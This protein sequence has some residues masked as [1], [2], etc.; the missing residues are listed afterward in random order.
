MG[1]LSKRKFEERESYLTTWLL[2]LIPALTL[3]G[4]LGRSMDWRLDWLGEFKMQAAALSFALFLW[5]LF[6]REWIKTSVFLTLVL[7]NLALIA[8]HS[9]LF[10][11][12][13]EL[14]EDSHVFT[15]TYQNLQGAEHKADKLREVLENSNADIVL[16]VNVP[17]QIYRNLDS[18]LGDYQLQ[19]QTF[20]TTGKMKLILSRT[21]GVDRGETA[22]ENGLWVSR[23]VG[24][25]KLTIVLTDI[26]DPWHSDAY[27]RAKQK[28]ADLSEFALSRDEPVVLAGNFGASGWS[29]LL[30]DLETR[31]GL[32]PRGKLSESGT[33]LPLLIRRP[34]DHIY[35]HPGI[36]V[37]DVAAQDLIGT[38]HKA[39]SAVFRIAPIRKE[40]EFFELQPV[41]SES[42]L[43]QPPL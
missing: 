1:Y 10:Q 3:L 27:A 32:K 18:V 24:S 38:K 33:D 28:V 42:E 31:G 30:N 15:V 14:P 19:N 23:V 25:R 26:A 13:S 40:I 6:K 41:M 35:T 22:D 17:V 7:M 5:C 9:H 12:A 20:D 29:W 43:L 39:V 11:K 16:W 36:E 4:T 8:T 37:A 34:T 21:P 2:V